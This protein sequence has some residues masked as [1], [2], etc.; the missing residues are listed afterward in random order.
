MDR[1]RGV[2]HCEVVHL[3]GQKCNSELLQTL[4]L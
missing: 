2:V 4:V 1:L 3:R